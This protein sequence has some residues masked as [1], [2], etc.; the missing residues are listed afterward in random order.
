MFRY[1][2]LLFIYLLITVTLASKY[3]DEPC[4]RIRKP[5]HLITTEEKRLF[6]EGYQQLRENNKLTI[7]TQTHAFIKH[8]GVHHGSNAFFWHEYLLWE[9]E[10][11]I[12][13]LGE[14]FKCFSLPYWDFTIDSGKKNDDKFIFSES[15]LGGDG[16]I[17]NNLCIKPQQNNNDENLWSLDRYSVPD[18][19]FCMEDEISPNCCLK[20]EASTVISLPTPAELAAVISN[21]QDWLS[22]SFHM[23]IIHGIVHA[24]FGND[25]HIAIKGDHSTDD[26][27][28]WGIHSYMMFI[29]LIWTSCNNFDHI[30]INHP[31]FDDNK[32]FFD[33]F[34][35]PPDAA[36]GDYNCGSIKWDDIMD[37]YPMDSM[38]L[39]WPL[40]SKDFQI[41]LKYMYNPID[42]GVKY[43]L[44]DFLQ[45]THLDK[46]CSNI[47]NE[48]FIKSD[49]NDLERVGDIHKSDV[50]I[51]IDEL[52]DTYI[53]ENS[54]PDNIIDMFEIVDEYSCKY[55]REHGANS[56]WNEDT[57]KYVE[58]CN[59]RNIDDSEQLTLKYLLEF[60]GVKDNEC[61]R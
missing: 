44:G 53:N 22:F 23:N 11:Q 21:Q 27:I 43:E 29:R 16:D 42:W 7:I 56:C 2:Q 46:W 26:P 1:T 33:P 19:D 9:F 41:K 39:D 55:N 30:N 32:I 20:R 48:W 35:N 47:N 15:L 4:D 34:C 54:L 5:W 10:T 40:V 8:R 38:E 52:W 45:N 17:D 49:I 18:P 60:D 50:Q 57:F 3:L 61:L 12:R 6:V 13:A 58:T 36:I 59:D 51:F 28:F 14:K 37:Y 25:D 24:F 31:S